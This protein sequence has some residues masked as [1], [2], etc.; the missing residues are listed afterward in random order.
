MK[1]VYPK[2]ISNR[3]HKLKNTIPHKE[4][5][6]SSL[7]DQAYL[8]HHPYGGSKRFFPNGSSTPKV[9]PIRKQKILPQSPRHTMKEAEDSSP[10]DH[11]SIR[12]HYSLASPFL[13]LLN[14]FLIPK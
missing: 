8:E 9:S 5:E 7:V 13:L 14:E 1:Y 6:D 4:V 11:T 10:M 2:T 3:S 12:L